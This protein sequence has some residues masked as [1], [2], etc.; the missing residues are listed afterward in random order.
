MSRHSKPL[1]KLSDSKKK[2][3]EEFNNLLYALHVTPVLDKICIGLIAKETSKDPTLAE[4]STC[5]KA[6]AVFQKE[7][8]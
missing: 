4:R 8:S 2:E 1:S 5:G 3:P 6:Q 7:P